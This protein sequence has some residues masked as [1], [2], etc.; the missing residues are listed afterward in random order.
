MESIT[1]SSVLGTGGNR[2]IGRA[3]VDEA[4]A[5]G[6]KRVY[7]GMRRPSVFADP[8]VV[9]LILDVTDAGQIAAAVEQV[10]A[11]DLLINNAGIAIYDDLTDPSVLE[12]HLAV[13][14]FGLYGVTRAF[15]PLLVR[16][17]GTVVNNLSLN[18][19]A[20]LPIIPAYSVSKAAA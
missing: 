12:R 8:R 14:V 18:A 7:V 10:E 11:L 1:G 6:A 3:L 5:R 2:G 20:P 9:S 17:G 15:L 19:F 4:L 16:S 13:N